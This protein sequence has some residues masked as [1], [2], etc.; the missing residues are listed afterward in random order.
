M[1]ENDHRTIWKSIGW[2]GSIE[3]PQVDTPSDGDFKLHFEQLLNP[4][5]IEEGE[6]FDVSDSPYIPL[7][8]DPIEVVEV[9]EAADTCKES[10]SFIGVTPA[11][12][13]CLSMPWIIFVTNMLNMVFCSDNY[14]FPAKWCYNKLIVL[15]KKGAR[16][17][18]GNYRG[19]SV[20]DS[21]GKLYG[22][23]LGNRLKQWM[24]VDNCQAGGQEERGCIEHILALRLIIDYAR[25]EKVKLFVLFV[26][27]S[28]AYDKVP[29]RTLFEILKKVG[30]GKRFL[31]A[32]I[33]IYKDTV[34]ILNSEYI[35]A[36]IGV[37]QGG[38]MSCL[39][40][41]I[42]LNILAVMIKALGNDSYLQDVH[43]LM[44]MD[45]TVLLASTRE[46]MIEK[47]KVLMNF[48]EKYGMFVNE[49]K[50]Q[51]MVI[52]G[53]AA[54]RYEFTASNVVVKNT[55]SYIYL[56]SPFTEN[57]KMNDVIALHAKSRAKDL[58]K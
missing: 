16:M 55:K 5:G 47:F 19:I 9:I 56:G 6:P 48:C 25:K 29:R 18:C 52:N 31:S 23:V 21:I 2:D 58:N 24:D 49:L 26:D 13:T 27:F 37:K 32:L 4:A 40:F 22:K 10:K 17:I 57:G 44:L 35:K 15:F 20:G 3:E 41:I 1:K 28:K 8:D 50:T 45:D 7:L 11:I 14:V 46:K 39:L 12:F 36:K 38:P 51:F 53:T 42:Y 34:N 43:A 30:C 54:D 33:A